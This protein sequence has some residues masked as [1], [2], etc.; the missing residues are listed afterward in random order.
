MKSPKKKKTVKGMTL[1][2]I[3]ISLFVFGVAALIMVRIATVS[4][5]FTM[6]ASHV[7]KRTNIEA[8]LAENSSTGS[9]LVQEEDSN[10]RVTVKMGG[11]EVRIAGKAYTTSPAAAGDN[12]ASAD[13]D[14]EFVTYD[15]SKTKGSGLWIDDTPVPGT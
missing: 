5:N 15:T 10:Y 12:F 4:N 1:V 13:Y 2:E 8:P 11:K 6:K 14:I 3:I 7:T 9:D